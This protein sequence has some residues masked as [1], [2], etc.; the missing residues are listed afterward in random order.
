MAPKDRPM[1]EQWDHTRL[2]GSFAKEAS[3]RLGSYKVSTSG[4]LLVKG[5]TAGN[6]ALL[7]NRRFLVMG[8]VSV[9]ISSTRSSPSGKYS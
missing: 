2:C 7:C 9:G 5:G 6:V 8:L 4:F 1:K 3:L